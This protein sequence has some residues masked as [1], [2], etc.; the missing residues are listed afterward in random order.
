MLSWRPAKLHWHFMWLS[1]LIF[2]AFLRAV[3][4]SPSFT[5]EKAVA[6]VGEMLAD[7]A[8]TSSETETRS[9]TGL[10]NALPALLIHEWTFANS[11]S[12]PCMD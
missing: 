8:T 2:S 10:P 9:C 3:C 7:D 12:C 11:Q 4:P 5:G 1:H 6:R